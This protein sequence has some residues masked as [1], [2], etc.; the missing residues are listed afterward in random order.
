M[1]PH[2]SLIN[3][4]CT[5]APG[6]SRDYSSAARRS[7]S[8]P[9]PRNGNSARAVTFMNMYRD[10]RQR[11]V[12]P[13]AHLCVC[14]CIEN[15]FFFYIVP[16]L[17]GQNLVLAFFTAGLRCCSVCAINL[18]LATH[19]HPLPPTH[20]SSRP[21]Q[22]S[23][24]NYLSR[25]MGPPLSLPLQLSYLYP[26]C[27]HAA[28]FFSYFCCLCFFLFFF[29]SPPP[30]RLKNLPSPHQPTLPLANPPRPPAVSARQLP[31]LDSRQLSSS[32]AINRS[33]L[34]RCGICNQSGRTYFHPQ[35]I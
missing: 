30:P 17:C 6:F 26:S 19:H 20:P 27:L 32:A 5:A 23:M 7:S 1:D 28:F 2:S 13:G 4:L 3:T 34:R 35:Q 29:L 33:R 31:T 9:L 22:Q 18:P 11:A 12:A 16:D 15:F 21:A 24:G 8:S 10:E 14:V 25:S